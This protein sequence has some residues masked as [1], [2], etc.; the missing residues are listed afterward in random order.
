MEL[1]FYGANCVRLTTKKAKVVIDDNLGDLGLKPVI[2]ADE[3]AVYSGAHGPV[4]V[5]TQLIIDQ[6]G[7]YEVSDVSVKGIAARGHMDEADKQTATI[8]RID[9]EDTRVGILGHIYPELSDAQLEALGTIDVLIVPVGGS[10][11]T[12]DPVGALH[13]IKEIEPKIV[14]PTHY[15]EKGLKYPVPQLS[16][17]EALKGLAMEP[18]ET[19][20]KLKIKPADFGES[21]E[22]IVLERQ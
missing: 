16:L 11:Y 5:D 4:S 14:I 20:P 1:Q 12:L 7:E 18:K 6:P 10:G 22:L 13:L 21:T 2:K 19:V 15:D 9:A 3:I 17:E 8:Y